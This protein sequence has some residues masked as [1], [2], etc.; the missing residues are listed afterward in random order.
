MGFSMLGGC[1]LYSLRSV[2]GL[3]TLEVFWKPCFSFIKDSLMSLHF[4]IKYFRLNGSTIFHN[5]SFAEKF[6]I[7]SARKR[8]VD[9]LMSML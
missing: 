9:A 2:L 7:M 5:L 4:K 3:Q 8:L 6:F 1:W